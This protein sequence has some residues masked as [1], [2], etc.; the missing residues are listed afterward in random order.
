MV[1]ACRLT[2]SRSPLP[3]VLPIT[4]LLA[5]RKPL[6]MLAHRSYSTTVTLYPATGAVPIW[7]VIILPALVPI[8]QMISC[9][10]IGLATRTKSRLSCLSLRARSGSRK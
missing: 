10:T 4:T 6:P 7:P 1:R 3:M 2:F 9:A 5:L 8:D